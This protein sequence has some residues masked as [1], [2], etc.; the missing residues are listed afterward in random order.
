MCQKHHQ[1]IVLFNLFNKDRKISFDDEF[2]TPG[3]TTIS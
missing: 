3:L 1:A 2:K